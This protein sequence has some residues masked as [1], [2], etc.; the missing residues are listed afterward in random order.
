MTK[1]TRKDLES[2]F[3]D[4]QRL[5]EQHR[6]WDELLAVAE[7]QEREHRAM[8]RRFTHGQASYSQPVSVAVKYFACKCILEPLPVPVTWQAFAGYRRDYQLGQALRE[9]TV[10]ALLAHN[11]TGHGLWCDLE[12]RWQL[13]G[14]D[15]SEDI[16]A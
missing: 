8:G 5:C 4:V 9:L 15:Y 3:F 7:R 13:L 10:A 14:I 6:E 11:P 16:A 2:L 12:T 1:Q